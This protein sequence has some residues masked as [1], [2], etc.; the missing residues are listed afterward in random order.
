MDLLGGKKNFPF[1]F[2]KMWTFHLDLS[3]LVHDWWNIQVDGLA[4]FRVAEKL[5]NVK[6]NVRKWNQTSF[7]HIFLEKEGVSKEIQA[8]QQSIQ[9][10][11]YDHSLVMKEKVLL[12]IL[13]N[14][15]GKEE[16]FW[17]QHSRIIWL[18]SGDR[19]TIFFHLSM[20]KH[21]ASNHI[22]MINFNNKVL[23]KDVDFHFVVS[24]YF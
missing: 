19:N 10:S 13:H 5:A 2:E 7:G 16:E 3:N 4:I 15:V 1:R 21:R 14:I 22:K 23:E 17:K 11:R 12:S 6:D 18:K 9:V 8:M 24:S 20:L